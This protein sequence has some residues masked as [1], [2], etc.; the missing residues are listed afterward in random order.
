MTEPTASLATHDIDWQAVARPVRGENRRADS[1]ENRKLAEFVC[2]HYECGKLRRAAV[3]AEAM[4]QLAW[5]EGY[6]YLTYDSVFANESVRSQWSFDDYAGALA[7]PLKFEHQMPMWVNKIRPRVAQKIALLM[8]GPTRAYAVP[9]TGDPDDVAAAELH[10]R[11][12]QYLWTRGIDPIRRRFT[13]ALWTALMGNVAWIHPWWDANLS[14]EGDVGEPETPAPAGGTAT[15]EKQVR[16]DLETSK[17]QRAGDVNWDFYTIFDVTEPEL[18]RSVGEAPW[19]IVSKWRTIEWLVTNYGLRAEDLHPDFGANDYAQAMDRF[20][21]VAFNSMGSA[22]H[23]APKELKLIHELWRPRSPACPQGARLIVAQNDRQL[24]RRGPN[25]Y[26]HGQIPLIPLA[27]YTSQRF[28][29]TS[30]VF[31]AMPAQRAYNETLSGLRNLSYRATGVCIES[32]GIVVP[33]DYVRGGEVLV[34]E[35]KT[36][37]GALTEN[38]VRFRP[39]PPIRPELYRN[40]EMYAADID[41]VMSVNASTRGEAAFSGQSGRHAEELLARDASSLYTLRENVTAALRAAF[42]QSLS[43]FWQFAQT[44]RALVIPGSRFAGQVLRFK[45]A[46]LFPERLGRKPGIHDFNVQV[47]LTGDNEFTQILRE[48]ETMTKLGYWSPQNPADVARVNRMIGEFHAIDADRSTQERVNVDGEHDR[49]LAGDTVEPNF[50]DDDE[51]HVREHRHFTTTTEFRRA[52]RTLPGLLEKVKAHE[53]AHL[54][55][56][57]TKAAREALAIK[58]AQRYY[59]SMS[60]EPQSGGASP[61]GPAGGLGPASGLGAPPVSVGPPGGNGFGGL[62]RRIPVGGPLP[63]QTAGTGPEL[64]LGTLGIG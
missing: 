31:D 36:G 61:A 5:G 59:Q 6:Q 13:A 53:M 42:A 8:G 63:A 12:C 45:G 24:L 35:Y 38:K 46:D 9:Q 25:P 22:T 43:L 62:P 1:D 4:Q 10:T 26:K 33:N 64:D 7:E 3:E 37:S 48:I 41:E 30:S 52:A 21:W 2:R 32:E 11:L 54:V 15:D 28:H 14:T 29:P 44:E 16:T 23:T 56:K 55:A 27:E 47:E 18:C 39:T 20:S 40:L 60:A 51:Y 50:G 17:T 19:L 49:F 57:H 34:V 58:Q